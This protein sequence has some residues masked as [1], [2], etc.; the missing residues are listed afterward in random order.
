MITS[1]VF[2]GSSNL[3]EGEEMENGDNL[4]CISDRDAAITYAVEAIPLVDHYHFR[5]VMQSAT[6]EQPLIVQPDDSW[7]APYYDPANLN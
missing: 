4:L 7:C 2:T 3:S 5:A 6:G 1:L